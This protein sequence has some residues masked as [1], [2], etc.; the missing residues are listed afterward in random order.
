MDKNRETAYRILLN[1][2]NKNKYS[3]IEINKRIGEMRPSSPGFVRELVY[4][5][6]KNQMY[7]DYF[8]AQLVSRG[9]D[10]L[11]SEPHILLRMG[12]YQLIFMSSV[13][14]YAAVS[15]TVKMAKKFCFYQSK[16]INGVLRTFQREKDQLRKPDEE[17]DIVKA[18]SFKYSYNPWITSLWLKQYNEE[19]A[20]EMMQAGNLMPPFT[21][22]INNL[23][24]TK[25][26][27]I[28][29]LV[30]H[31]IKVEIP[32]SC[33]NV[34]NVKGSGLLELEEY[35][36]GLFFI[37]D[38]ASSMA[39]E[40]LDPKPMDTVIDIC[41]APGG[42]TVTAA[43]LMENKG[44]ILAF[45]IYENKLHHIEERASRL[46]I[47]IIKT[48]QKDGTIL[49]ETLIEIADKVICDVPCTGLGVVRRRPE[50]KYKNIKDDGKELAVKQLKIL[51]NASKY[52]KKGGDLLYSTC[53]INSIENS[54]VV[55]AFI[56][57]N[58]NFKLISTRQLLP[59]RDNSDGF[60][61][62]VM[63][64]KY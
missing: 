14:D 19:K 36:K 46:G 60:Y 24:T 61:Y 28:E 56:K 18:L 27:L 53:T 21:I 29:S 20:E 31:G 17:E 64:K 6:L 7:L 52:V 22:R 16:M 11:K 55:E 9:I 30:K 34:L 54:D 26:N 63:R 58:Q 37:Q 35:K 15:E 5:V 39:V 45:D 44:Q 12:L 62:C 38:I 40:Y 47:D 8:L 25:E 51:K 32:K 48:F 57:E 10:K 1:I 4:G 41:A 13:P 42:K 3:N 33:E 49:D 2:K 23:K 59:T 50:I 43:E